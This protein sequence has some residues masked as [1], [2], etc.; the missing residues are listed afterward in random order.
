MAT[1]QN[2]PRETVK[3]LYDYELTNAPGKSL[4]GIEVSY[5]PN[6]YTPPHRHSGA[7]VVGMTIEGEIL[8]GMNGNPPQVYK[9]GESFRELPGCHHTVGENNSAEHPAKLIATFVIDT[10]IVKEKGYAVL[11]QID[12]GYE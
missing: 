7:T 10:A 11:T 3:V 1:P 2:R 6:G 8:S 5:L 12:E 4:I 9:V